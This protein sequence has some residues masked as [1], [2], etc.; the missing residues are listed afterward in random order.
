MLRGTGAQSGVGGSVGGVTAGVASF[1]TTHDGLAQRRRHWVAESPKAAVL[2]VHGIGEHSGRYE[3]VG[4]MLSEAGYDVLAPD[5][6]GFGESGGRRAYVGHFGEYLTDVRDLLDARRE[7]GVP[8]VLMGHS[9]GGLISTRYLVSDRPQPDLAVLS[10]PALAAEIPTWQ[11]LAVPVISR[12]I[13]T[14][15][16]KNDFDGSILSRD[17]EVQRAYDEDPLRVGGATAALG[18]AIMTAMA[19]TAQR[20]DRISVPTYVLQGADDTLVP[21]AASEAIGELDGV[22]RRVWP[23]LRHESLNE[24]EWRDVLGEVIAWLDERTA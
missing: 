8:V 17:V 22:T 2:L 5:L 23:G 21:P 10:A 1:G 4:D 24:P 15:H 9:M 7:L 16:V 20:L 12:V 18:R 3:H 6:R 19:T 13:P 14:L 11:R